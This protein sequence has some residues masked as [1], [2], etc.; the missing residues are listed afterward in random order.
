MSAYASAPVIH[1]TYNAYVVDR[2]DADVEA[3]CTAAYTTLSISAGR[4][5]VARHVNESRRGVLQC[6]PAGHGTRR[7][8]CSGHVP[9]G[10]GVRVRLSTSSLCSPIRIT[11]A[12]TAPF[13]NGGSLTLRSGCG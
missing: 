7:V 12:V 13:P 1:C 6:S 9:R 4:N 10:A 5:V 8:R 3:I 2:T 11:L